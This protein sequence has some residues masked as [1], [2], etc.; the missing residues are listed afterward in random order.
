MKVITRTETIASLCDNAVALTIPSYQRP[1]VWPTEDV[2]KL[3]SDIVE[4]HQSHQ[5]HYYIG[6]IISG[7]KADQNR[8]GAKCTYEVIDGQQRCTTLTLLALAFQSKLPNHPLLEFARLGNQPR[9]TFMV[10][11]VVQDFLAVQAGLPI[12]VRTKGPEQTG[13][14]KDYLTH[15]QNGLLAANQELEILDAKGVDLSALADYIFK[16]VTWV[17]NVIPTGM[18]PNTLFARINTGGVQLEQSDILKAQLLRKISSKKKRYDAIW[19][20]CENLQDYF[21]RNV[22]RLFPDAS[23]QKLADSDLAVFNPK[24]FDLDDS[25]ELKSAGITIAELAVHSDVS[26]PVREKKEK[27]KSAPIA[28]SDDPVD[29]VRCRSII[30]FPL[31][32]MHTFRIFRSEHPELADIDSRLNE[33][34]FAEC[35]KEFIDT[36]NG[37][38]ACNFIECLWKVRYQFDKWVVKWTGSDEDK[39]QHLRL[40]SVYLTVSKGV[41]R[42]ARSQ[43]DTSDLSQLQAVRYF[44]GERSAQYWLSSFLALMLKQPKADFPDALAC[45]ESI[46]NTL[47]LAKVTQK[48][49]SFALM[50]E[51]AVPTESIGWPEHHLSAAL[52][53][54]FEHYW[55]QKLEYILW[56]KRTSLPYLK[57]GKWENYRITSKNSVEHVHPQNHQD[58]ERQL[59]KEH[60]HMFG[61]L[62]LLSPGENSTYSNQSPEKKRVD[63]NSKRTYDSLKLASVFDLMGQGDWNQRTIE[64]HQSAMISMLC[65]HYQQVEKWL[66]RTGNL[67]G[68]NI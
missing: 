27:S 68:S 63:F 41:K 35:F 11:D 40:T 53:T 55:F 3:L 10:R 31:L 64:D 67:G 25:P 26:S 62:A 42:L 58:P 8:R 54:G 24:L 61:N 19:Q 45:L 38:Q 65:E 36:A 22:R 12:T 29:D 6:T 32:L 5:A 33:A 20:A 14:E 30:S 66:N 50:R 1:Y 15:I 34:R 49:A 59:A 4:A 28:D 23:W 7:I 43:R 47:S 39:E 60:L 18:N 2:R 52:G 46:D 9:L 21:E 16:D 57:K 44:T 17:H 37:T 13:T 51:R 48:E 56:K